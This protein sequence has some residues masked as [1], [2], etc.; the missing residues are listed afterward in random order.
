M[1]N[2]I[3]NE[4]IKWAAVEAARVERVKATD[5]YDIAI[6]VIAEVSK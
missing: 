4:R 6:R 3:I 5:A 2:E 1:D